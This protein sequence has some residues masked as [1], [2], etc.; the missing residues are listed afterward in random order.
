MVEQRP[1]ALA[2]L[3]LDQLDEGAA[4]LHPPWIVRRREPEP[5][6]FARR[7]L[8]IGRIQ[9]HVVEVVL[10]LRLR[11]DEGDDDSL[12]ELEPVRAGEPRDAKPDPDERA[13][14]ARPLR[15]E[16]RQL[17]AA[18]VGADEREPVGLAR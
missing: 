12:A 13:G 16:E 11:L 6:P 9:R 17:P 14:V 15:L 3:A 4:D 7:C 5:Q 18:G 8:G 1:L 2:R 10:D